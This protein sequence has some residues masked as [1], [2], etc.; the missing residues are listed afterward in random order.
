VNAGATASFA[1]TAANA[2]TYQWRFNGTPIPNET[3][4]WLTLTGVGAGNVGSYDVVVK[5]SGGVATT[6][7]AAT[8]TLGAGNNPP[9][10]GS[11]RITTKKNTA[12]TIARAALVAKAT[13]P[14]AGNTLTVSAVGASSAQ[15]GTVSLDAN[16]VIYT[17]AAGFLGT[18]TF[19]YTIS[20]GAGGT[21]NGTVNVSVTSLTPIAAGRVAFGFRGKF[22]VVFA[23][24]AGTNY[25]LQRATDLTVANPWSPIQTLAAGDDGLLPTFDP[26]PPVGHAYYRIVQLP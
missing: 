11:Y 19:T 4:P 17:P 10:A 23:G 16:N 20:D 21:A 22:D 1:V 5:G 7:L 24:T 6:S 2:A 12:T 13:D 14:D 8:L 3:N 26:N 15:G 9:T 25:Q 18:D